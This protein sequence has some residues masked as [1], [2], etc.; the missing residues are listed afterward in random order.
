ML[1]D[2]SKYGL[3]YEPTVQE[4]IRAGA[5]IVCFSGDKLL[6]GP[7]AGIIVGRRDYIKKIKKHPLT[8]AF[9]IDKSRQPHGATIQEYLSEE[10]AIR[11]IPVL[12][13]LTQ[14][15]M[16]IRERAEK[17]AAML[18]NVNA[19]VEVV[20]CESQVGGGSMPLERLRSSAVALK[21]LSMTTAAF[22]E[23][24]R[25]AERPVICRV[26]EDR[27]LMDMRTVQPG[28]TELIAA[29][30]AGILGVK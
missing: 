18:K 2:L 17:L 3:T 5:A 16:E 13:M 24:L 9:R 26:Q 21:P 11:N 8:R 14:P 27:A 4:S 20:D 19:R 30:V 29:E 12:R 15:P 25:R 23:A 7:Q 22:E 10:N 28:E 1:I 6:G